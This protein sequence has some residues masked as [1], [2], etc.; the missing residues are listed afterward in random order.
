MRVSLLVGQ[1]LAERSLRWRGMCGIKR[2]Q[3]ARSGS[4]F[5]WQGCPAA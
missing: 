4:P 1:F 5:R 3:V 2:Q